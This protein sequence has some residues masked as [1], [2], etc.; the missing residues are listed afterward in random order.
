MR[1]INQFTEVIGGSERVALAV[2]S[3]IVGSEFHLERPVL[4]NRKLAG[5]TAFW[6]TV[7]TYVVSD[8]FCLL[9]A[10]ELSIAL[11]NLTGAGAPLDVYTR[12]LPVLGVFLVAYTFAQLYPSVGMSPVEEFRRLSLSTSAVFAG[13]AGA[14][15]MVRGGEI[16]SRGIYVFAWVLSL[17]ILPLGRALARSVYSKRSW[18]GIHTVVLGAGITGRRIVK[19]LKRRPELGL[20][21]VA[22]LDDDPAKIGDLE[23]VPVLGPLSLSPRLVKDMNLRYGI[24]AMPG[25]QCDKLVALLECHARTF[26]HLIV[27][28]DLFGFGS[29]RMPSH[30]MGGVLAFEVRQQLLIPSRRY[31]KRA[32]D[33]SVTIVG[34]IFILPLLFLIA[35]LIKLESRGPVLF[36]QKRMGQHGASFG[37]LKFRSMVVGAEEALK[38]LLKNNPAMKE[39]YEKYHKLRD[40][41]R[42]TRMGR[43]LRKTSLDELPQLWNVLMGEMSLVGPRAYM[44]AELPVM[45]KSED[46]ILRTWPGITGLWQ[47][48]GR[49]KTTFEERLN[50][51]VFYV[52]NWSLWLDI[53]IL[54]KTIRVVLCL[55]DAY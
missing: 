52:R 44:P 50:F 16:Y 2:D 36:R 43:L 54:A 33:L 38:E 47:V 22:V 48:S 28:P 18:W 23:G 14:T 53:Y 17:A 20:R 26:R 30:D 3:Q 12:L 15:F 1:D 42:I 49:N 31:L 51:D 4:V 5:V 21:P 32:I 9:I 46:L 25:V 41:P 10:L 29:M 45:N 39:E 11:R 24:V 6:K 35:L 55:E 40:D 27:I 7:A 13:I 8:T 19:E 34:G 37:A